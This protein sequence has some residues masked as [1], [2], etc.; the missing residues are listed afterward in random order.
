MKLNVNH[1]LSDMKNLMR[2][3]MKLDVN[4]AISDMKYLISGGV[5][6]ED[7]FLFF[8]HLHKTKNQIVFI[9]V[10]ANSGQSAISFLMNCPNGRS[11][12]F[13]PNRLYEP[14][15]AGV[16][17][18]LGMARFEFHMCGL[19]DTEAELDLYVPHVDGVP[20]MEEASLTLAQFKKSW[21]QDRLQSYGKKIKIIPFRAN[22]KIADNIIRQADV[23]KIDAEGAEMQ[24]LRGMQKL[25]ENTFP[26]F[27]IE[28]NDWPNV[29]EYLKA[30]GYGAYQYNKDANALLPKSGA[31]TNCFYLR[32]EHFKVIPDCLI[33]V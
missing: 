9:D 3:T 7:D 23:V 12:S 8:K 13:E 15:L 29:T 22:F 28:N 27:L 21:V 17:D 1:V 25:I 14:V 4:H 32:S 6:H 20:Y 33:A 16:R 31:S 5:P 2:G 30:F 18:L 10:G 24:V 11:I 19:S 26:I